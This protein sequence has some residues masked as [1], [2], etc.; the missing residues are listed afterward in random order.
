M[1]GDLQG[2]VPYPILIAGAGGMLGWDLARTFTESLGQSRVVALGH[3]GLDITRPDSIATALD[4]Y[5]PRVLVNAAAY[6]NV[7]GAESEPQAARAINASGPACLAAACAERGIRLVHFSTDQ[8]FDGQ[9]AEPRREDEEPNPPNTY[10]RTKLEGETAALRSPG[11]LVLRVQWLYGERKDRFTPLRKKDVF[12]PFSD[13]YGSPTWTRLL[14]ETVLELLDRDVAG[15]FHFAHDDFA[16]WLEVFQFVKAELH[17][18]VRLEPK[19]T[20]EV[21]LPARR[22]LYSVLSNRKLCQALG[23]SGMGSWKDPLRQFLGVVPR[24]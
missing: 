5:E 16:S 1:R 18:A 11:A 22:P 2:G 24:V 3:Q 13:Q 17:L 8:V 7:D 23:R 6:T 19:R 14:A 21:T 15:L 20:A 4:R 9:A 10:A 12:T